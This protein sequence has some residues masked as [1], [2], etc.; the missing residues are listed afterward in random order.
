[1]HYTL[2]DAASTPHSKYLQGTAPLYSCTIILLCLHTNYS[3]GSVTT[4]E[5]ATAHSNNTYFNIGMAISSLQ[6]VLWHEPPR[7]TSR[8]QLLRILGVEPKGKDRSGRGDKAHSTVQRTLCYINIPQQTA[9]L[10][11]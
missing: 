7:Y 5:L 1:M 9:L 3:M 8:T 11:D 10:G 6:L 4:E 2:T